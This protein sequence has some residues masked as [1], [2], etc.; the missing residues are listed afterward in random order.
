[1]LYMK[2][3]NKETRGV[4]R[5]YF[6]SGADPISRGGGAEVFSSEAESRSSGTK[7]LLPLGHNTQKGGADYL[8][9]AKER[10][11]PMPPM[12]AFFI[13]G[14]NILFRISSGAYPEG[15]LCPS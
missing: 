3:N 11:P 5:I 6:L 1:M 12:R 9:I 8:I 13:R 14:R 4:S 2:I 7:T 15:G 10:L